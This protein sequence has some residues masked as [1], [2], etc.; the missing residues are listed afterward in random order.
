MV[1]WGSVGGVL[2]LLFAYLCL[3]VLCS[4]W[5]RE[6]LRGGAVRGLCS[7]FT[8]FFCLGLALTCFVAVVLYLWIIAYVAVWD[9]LRSVAVVALVFLVSFLVAVPRRL[10]SR[11]PVSEVRKVGGL[12]I[13]VCSSSDVDAWCGA[14]RV[15]VTRALLNV[16]NLDELRAIYEHERAHLRD[17]LLWIPHLVACLWLTTLGSSIV[18]V[19]V[20]WGAPIPRISAVLDVA[21]VYIVSAIATLSALLPSWVAEH[22]ADLR[23]VEAVGPQAV[24]RALVKV[25]LYQVLKKLG[26]SE[27]VGGVRLDLDKLFETSSTRTRFAEILGALL[28]NSLNFPKCIF[29]YV[30]RP[31]YATHPPTLLRIAFVARAAKGSAR[32]ARSALPAQGY[33]RG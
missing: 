11:C 30:L 21:S 23:A 32:G 25:G 22:E 12:E 3:A 1:P 2:R 31:R 10:A 26:V 15:F 24:A 29:E 19:L 5:Y 16:L 4:W 17:V 6:F 27:A 33:P 28:I 14:G 18:V 13:V 8:K 20:V 9:V 7:L